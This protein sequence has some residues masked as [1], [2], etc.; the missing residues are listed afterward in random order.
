MTNIRKE[1]IAK[2]IEAL[3]AKTVENGATEAEA[4]L[5]MKKAQDLMKEYYLS[6]EDI[7][8][9]KTENEIIIETVTDKYKGCNISQFYYWLG[10]LFDVKIITTKKFGGSHMVYG[11]EQDVKLVLWFHD[12]IVDSMIKALEVHQKSK[13][14]LDGVERGMNKRTLNNSFIKGFTFGVSDKI[15]KMYIDKQNDITNDVRNGI[16]STDIIQ[17]SKN[18]TIIKK[19]FKDHKILI[20]EKTQRV[21][22]GAKDNYDMGRQKGSEIDINRPING[23]TPSPTTKLIS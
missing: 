4:L 18:S 22:C 14:Y 20:T 2:K 8:Q 15:Q 13:T 9:Y 23:S 1:K 7:E 10:K 17:Y 19:L 6:V 12:F 11:F 3:L 16:D 21:R 5:A